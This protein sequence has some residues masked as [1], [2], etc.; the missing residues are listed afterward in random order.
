MINDI[1]RLLV[2]A[3]RQQRPPVLFGGKRTSAFGDRADL[4]TG[5][6]LT[7]YH[8][9]TYACV[10][11]RS[12][13]IAELDFQLYK[14]SVREEPIGGNG[15]DPLSTPEPQEE[16]AER[17]RRHWKLKNEVCGL[18]P[19]FLDGFQRGQLDIQE[20]EVHPF[21]ELIARPNPQ[22]EP[23]GFLLKEKTEIHLAL[24]GNAFW[25]I[26]RDQIGL[27]REI[28]MLRPDRVG[29]MVNKRTGYV[30]GWVY[31]REDGQSINLK[32][33]DVIHFKLPSPTEDIWGWSLVKAG[34]YAHDT[35]TFMNVYH[36]NFFKNS[37]RPDYVLTTDNPI[38]QD[39]ARLIMEDWKAE[40]SGAERAHLPAILGYGLTP[41][42]LQLTN[43]DI[44]FIGIANWTLD[45]LIAIFGVPKAKLGLVADA[46]RSNSE[47]ADETFNRETIRPQMLR[48]SE[49]VQIGLLD[50][51]PTAPGTWLD[52]GF[53][54]PVPEDRTHELEKRIRE[55]NA[56]IRTLNEARDD[57]DL[58]IL[59]GDVGD[60]IKM[61]LQDVLIPVD[62][63]STGLGP[64]VGVQVTGAG[65]GRRALT[66]DTK[67]LPP[68][69]GLRAID[70]LWESETHRLRWWYG[71]V[72]RSLT[73]E[74][75]L[76]RFF[77]R[78]FR[79]QERAVL[80]AIDNVI[81]ERQAGSDPMTEQIIREALGPEVDDMLV[82]ALS[83]QLAALAVEE[84][85]FILGTLG[86]EGGVGSAHESIVSFLESKPFRVAGIIDVT[87]DSLR[88][89]IREW[90]LSDEG[91]FDLKRRVRGVFE[92][93]RGRA[94]NI[95]RTEAIGAL[96]AGGQAAMETARVPYKEW[97]SS[98][99]ERVRP[100]H[101]VADRQVVP[102]GEMFSVG[103]A[104]LMYP[105]DPA[106]NDPG[107]V[108]QCRCTTVPRYERPSQ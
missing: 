65:D 62:A 102:T 77:L 48:I 1:T 25:Y 28:W 83:A 58:D 76:Y 88:A 27:P 24:T 35:Q 29:A 18:K 95:S 101:V 53:P 45:Q 33:E 39:L 89:T 61:Q 5:D 22:H 99:D 47:A 106:C 46:N 69:P 32:P 85:T 54:D 90:A 30:A 20:I 43:T 86:F 12:T 13:R 96:N 37:A 87:K 26:L 7:A 72:A 10:R 75:A 15:G 56:G 8:H 105:G 59:P 17:R 70:A 63:S 11:T 94:A 74:R 34:A 98:H 16:M 41:K 9:Y 103:A 4:K 60:V 100:T 79:E 55:Y 50:L 97:L 19:R 51:Y 107:E 38:D 71:F 93:T 84:G 91:L 36:R 57:G 73:G 23:T 21:F 82:Q 40:F 44:Q 52:L 78:E 104:R 6:Q 80:A 64:I 49:Q 42:A 2:S 66:G 108:C 92:M 68:A 14:V 3:F 81:P 31:Y 67:A